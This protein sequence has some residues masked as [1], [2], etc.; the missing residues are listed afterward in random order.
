MSRKSVRRSLA[1]TPQMAQRL[2]QIASTKPRNVTE[3]DLIREAI[4]RYL[5]EQDDLAG[6]RK[7]FQRAFRQR[8]DLL[9][10]AVTFQLN[11]LIYLLGFDD[12]TL[13]DAIILARESGK[14]LLAQMQAVREYDEESL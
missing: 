8:I 7:H 4:R 11:V 14:T 6:S 13:R 2:N 12:E 1:M 9:E 5:D 10:E 3:A